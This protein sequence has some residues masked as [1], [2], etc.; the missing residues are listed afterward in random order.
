MQCHKASQS[1]VC[2]KRWMDWQLVRVILRH[3]TPSA[4]AICGV[5]KR[6]LNWLFLLLIYKQKV[7]KHDETKKKK[8]KKE[9]KT[10]REKIHFTATVKF[11]GREQRGEGREEEDAARLQM[12][13][14]LLSLLSHGQESGLLLEQRRRWDEPVLTA[15][16]E[17]ERTHNVN[18]TEA[19]VQTHRGMCMSILCYFRLRCN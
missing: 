12:M 7:I 8:R 15:Q 2:H 19:S 6:C 4:S 16:E 17:S 13:F 11:S 10:E 1:G 9:K 3:P 5:K 18:I 14:S